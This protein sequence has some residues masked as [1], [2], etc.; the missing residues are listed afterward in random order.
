MSNSCKYMVILAALIPSLS[1]IALLV[2][3]IVALQQSEI[4]SDHLTQIQARMNQLELRQTNNLAYLE[5]RHNGLETK[6]NNNFLTL[7]N[8]LELTDLR[9]QNR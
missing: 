7:R 4:R 2:T 5:N 9:F 1:L 3:L 6:V 8:R